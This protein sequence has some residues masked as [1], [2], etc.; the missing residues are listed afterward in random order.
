MFQ[1]PN[2]YI[3]SSIRK[4]ISLICSVPSASLALKATRRSIKR[5]N[6][7]Y[8]TSMQH[9]QSTG[10]GLYTIS[11]ERSAEEGRPTGERKSTARIHD[12][13]ITANKDGHPRPDGAHTHLWSWRGRQNGGS[14]SLH[15]RVRRSNTG[16]PRPNS[17]P[18][19]STTITTTTATEQVRTAGIVKRACR[20]GVRSLT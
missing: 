2:P 12:E 10:Q 5:S 19:Y 8:V 3:V 18:T 16:E 20:L 17:V 7:L 13:H 9:Q 1:E 14:P 4:V 11:G 6:A 15:S